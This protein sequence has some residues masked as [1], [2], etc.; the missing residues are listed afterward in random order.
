[1]DVSNYLLNQTLL[2]EAVVDPSNTR[3]ERRQRSD[4]GGRSATGLCVIN[5]VDLDTFDCAEVVVAHIA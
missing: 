4:L 5:V 3:T 2:G 1:M